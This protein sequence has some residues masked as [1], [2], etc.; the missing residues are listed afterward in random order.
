MML[1]EGLVGWGWARAG[2]GGAAVDP[3]PSGRSPREGSTVR[4]R[5]PNAGRSRR[6]TVLVTAVVSALVLAACGSSSSSSAKPSSSKSPVLLG[7]ATPLTGPDPPEGKSEVADVSDAI[8]YVNSHGGIDG[9]PLKLAVRDTMLTPTGAVTALDSLASAGVAAVIGE[10]TSTDTKAG[11]VAAMQ[12]HV[13]LLGPASAAQGLTAGKT[14]CFRD[15]YQVNQSTGSMMAVARALGW[16]KIAIATD[17]TDFGVSEN[18]SWS[19]LLPRNG[20][21]V[22]ANVTWTAPASTLTSQVL[23]IGHSGAQAVFVGAAEGPDAVLLAKTMIQEGVHIPL[24]GPGGVIG[25]GVAKAAGPS[26]DQLPLVLGFTS[27][28]DGVPAEAA[29]LARLQA[30]TGVP[31]AGGNMPRYY[32]GVL[33]LAAALRVTHGKGGIALVDALQSLG[34]F[35]MPIAAGPGTYEYYTAAHHSGLYGPNLF[36]IYKWDPSSSSF[37]RDASLSS[38]ANSAPGCCQAP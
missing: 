8:A 32:E 2:H 1:R 10:F 9:R 31:Q 26:Y 30:Q 5:A 36:S 27:Y 4:R 16:H 19:T 33:M 34:R 28:D 6:W 18:Q 29:L 24:F 14:Y 35:P 12:Q 20:F 25:T 37:V 21:Q 22:V 38:I 11:C 15:E 23:T 17:T 3:S 13:V 7:L